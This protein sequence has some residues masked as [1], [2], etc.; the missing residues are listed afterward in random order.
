[1][2]RTELVLYRN[3]RLLLLTAVLL[4]LGGGVALSLI[5][6]GR[7]AD[8]RREL[9]TEAD[10]RGTAVSTLAGDV[11]ALREQVLGE[12]KIP[13]APDPTTAVEDLPDR[14]EVPVPIP[15][16]PGADG[17]DGAVGEPGPSGSPGSDGKDGADG[18]DSTV[19]GPSGPA[20]P[21]GPQ[22]EP[23]PAGPQGAP[24]AD[25]AD[26]ADGV[27]GQSCPDG[28]S[29]QAPSYDP[30]ALVCRKNGAP[31]PEPDKPGGGNPQAE[32]ALDPQRRV[33]A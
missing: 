7:E 18:A 8:A 10:L 21:P 4:V 12:G 11:R 3:R 6:I 14:A 24:G 9:A 1:M 25:G 13:V 16:P 19:P 22:G 2:T 33:Y 27:D 15:G 5:L 17:E 31:G 23:G 26:G 32:G 29:L 30:D 20:G 28:Y